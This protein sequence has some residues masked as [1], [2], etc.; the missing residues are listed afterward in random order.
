MGATRWQ[1]VRHLVKRSVLLAWRAVR[2]AASC[3][4]AIL[5][6]GTF[7]SADHRGSLLIPVLVFASWLSLLT[8]VIV[9]WPGAPGYPRRLVKR[10]WDGQTASRAS[11]FTLKNGLSVQV[12]FGLLLAA[13]ASSCRCECG[14]CPAHRLCGRDGDA[15]DRRALPA[16]PRAGR[17]L[18]YGRSGEGPRRSRV[19]SARC[20]SRP[21]VAVTASRWSSRPAAG[22]TPPTRA[23]LCVGGFFDM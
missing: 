14:A 10:A 1:L 21:A 13:P 23:A 12:P 4:V 19:C 5:L 18:A 6:L 16:I 8:G 9:A 17:E 3:L 15:P 20:D 7:E 11:L 2:P 22:Q